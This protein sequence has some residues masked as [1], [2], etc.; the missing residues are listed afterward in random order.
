MINEKLYKVDDDLKEGLYRA[1]RLLKELNSAITREEIQEVAKKLFGKFGDSSITPPFRC[2][3]GDNIY[4]GEGSYFNYNSSLIDVA[5]IFVGDNVLVGPDCGFYTAEHPIDPASR[6]AGVEYGR[7]I[8]VE[9]DVWIGGHSTIT[10]GVRI[11]KGSI[12]GA[13]SVVTKDIP[14]NVIAFGNPCRIYREISDEDRS[15]WQDKVNSFYKSYPD[16]K[17]D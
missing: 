4:I 3:Y 11:G 2:D 12:I 8:I 9:D 10:S 1:R 13:G 17:D 6:K 14:E 16:L 15:Y 7:K 5:E